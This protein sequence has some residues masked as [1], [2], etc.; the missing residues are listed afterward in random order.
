M[1]IGTGSVYDKRC[2]QRSD[3]KQIVSLTRLDLLDGNYNTVSELPDMVQTL[4]DA[5]SMRYVK[6]GLRWDVTGQKIAHFP[7]NAPARKDLEGLI[8]VRVKEEIERIAPRVCPNGNTFIVGE[9]VA[10]QIAS[11]LYLR[12]SLPRTSSIGH[13]DPSEE[14]AAFVRIT[15]GATI[16]FSPS[17][18]HRFMSNKNA[19]TGWVSNFAGRKVYWVL[20]TQIGDVTNYLTDEHMEEVWHQLVVAAFPFIAPAVGDVEFHVHR[21]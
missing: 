17:Q 19:M 8:K 21:G 2:E 6:V 16:Q 3:Q 14:W 12:M 9:E 1:G 4:V 5:D 13:D 10:A 20:R 15:P 7:A 11:R 18:N